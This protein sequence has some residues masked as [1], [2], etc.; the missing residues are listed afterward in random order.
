MHYESIEPALMGWLHAS[1]RSA[2]CV[3]RRVAIVLFDGFSLLGA[4]LVAEVFHVA[5]ELVSAGVGDESV[6]DVSFLS[7][8]GGN[9]TCSSSVRVWTDGLD[10]RHYM[11]FDALFVAGGKGSRAAASD[12]RLVG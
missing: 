2:K 9:V 5:N 1:D 8:S 3:T 4:G 6:Y 10:A 11:G 12:E 7:A